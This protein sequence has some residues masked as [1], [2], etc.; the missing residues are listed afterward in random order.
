MDKTV[1]YCE[2]GERWGRYFLLRKKL[3]FCST[4]CIFCDSNY[5]QDAGLPA[6]ALNGLRNKRCGPGGGTRRLHHYTG[7]DKS[8]GSVGAK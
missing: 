7:C 3:N 2:L 8:G 6:M 5:N 1:K 4:I